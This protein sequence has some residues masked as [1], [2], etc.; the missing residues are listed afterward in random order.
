[1]ATSCSVISRRKAFINSCFASAAITRMCCSTCR[2]QHINI[3]IPVCC[4]FFWRRIRF[5]IDTGS[6]W[7]YCKTSTTEDIARQ[8]RKRLTKEQ[9][10]LESLNSTRDVEYCVP[11]PAQWRFQHMLFHR[12]LELWPMTPKFNAFISVPQYITGVSLVKIQVKIQL[13]LFKKLC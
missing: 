6:G 10:E 3:T 13:T 5:H 4:V 12:Y 8:Q 9:V 1:M 2:C 7:Q 11:P